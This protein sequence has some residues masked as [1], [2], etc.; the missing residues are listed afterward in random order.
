M[1]LIEEAE[2]NLRQVPALWTPEQI[3]YAP[4]AVQ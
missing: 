1:I 4:G 2:G 3:P